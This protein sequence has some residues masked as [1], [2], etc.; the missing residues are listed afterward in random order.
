[1]KKLMLTSALAGVLISSSAFAQTT[2]TGEIRVNYKSVGSSVATGTTTTSGRG[3]G[4]EQQLNIQTKG[5]LNVGGLDYAA[6]FSMEND[7]QQ[8]GTLFN[9]NSYIDFTNAS[10]GTTLSLSQDHIQRSDT[11]RSAAVLVGHTPNELSSSGHAS[12]RFSQ[13][14]GPA[15]GQSWTVS[16]LQQVGQF[17]TVSYSYAPTLTNGVSDGGLG[18]AT[19]VRTGTSPSETFNEND[20]EG[21]YEY[22]FVGSLG[23][24]G[25][26]AYYFNS[27]A[28][29]KGALTTIPHAQSYGASYNMG[30]FTIGYANKRYNVDTTALDTTEKHYGVAYAINNQATLGLIYGKADVESSSVT[31]KVKG[32]NLGYALGPVDLTVSVARNTDIAGTAGNDSDLAMVRFIG[33]F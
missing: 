25:L 22:G 11:D 33:K 32:I 4:T 18:A 24:K 31:Q 21:G 10:S 2:V 28:N 9:E 5:K 17:G 7:G 12:T 26:N 16:L 6:G 19:A 8:V 20:N 3:F 29:A 30:E 27:A 23:V 15:V 14:L 13:N 1:M